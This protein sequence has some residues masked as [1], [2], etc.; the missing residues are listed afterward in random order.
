MWESTEFKNHLLQGG[1]TAKAGVDSEGESEF[2]AEIWELVSLGAWSAQMW[3]R[4]KTK[5][6][7][8]MVG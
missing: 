6:N 4:G 8:E 1:E 3:L 5:C 2:S 7:R